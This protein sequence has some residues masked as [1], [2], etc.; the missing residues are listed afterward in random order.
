MIDLEAV[1]KRRKFAKEGQGYH[2]DSL[3]DNDS[4]ILDY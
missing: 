2:A 1:S 4:E 3:D